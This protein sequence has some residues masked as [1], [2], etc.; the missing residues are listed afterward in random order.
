MDTFDL[1]VIGA[2]RAGVAAAL[3]GA[4]AG[5]RVCL[6]EQ[7][8]IG[9][10][11]MRKGLYPF[12]AAM[13]ALRGQGADGLGKGA[14]DIE[15]LFQSI[16]GTGESIADNWRSQLAERGVDVRL[17]RG[18]LVSPTHIRA[19]SEQ[20][21]FEV[22][23]KT[24]VLAAG[25][26]PMAM[27]TLPY[28]GESIISTDDIFRIKKVPESVLISGGGAGGCEWATLFSLLGSKVF[29]CDEASRL[30]TGQEPEVMDAIER[31]MKKRKVKLL[32]GRKIV[33]HYKN[34]GLLDISLDGGVKFQVETIVLN[35]ARESN[36]SGLGCE[37]LGLRRGE[38]KEVLVNEILE[39]S[40]AGI[41]SAGSVSGRVS[42]AGISEEEGRVAADNALGKK[43]QI[44]PDWIPFIVRTDPEIA[45][46]GC[47]AEEAHHKGFRAVE[48][49]CGAGNP[50]YAMLWRRPESFFKVVAD[51]KSGRVIGGQVVSPHASELISL[52][53]LA[54]K[55]GMKVG[56]LAALAT[57]GTREIQG[58]QEAARACGRALKARAKSP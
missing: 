12:T 52:V 4:E 39:T 27:P 47:F 36:S 34:D 46:V 20:E 15:R 16:N 40:V 29:L 42:P 5:A 14:V 25:S 45:T 37:G 57:D 53:L 31:S 10:A 2:G 18:T 3:R 43:R 32:L 21:S 26:R 24:I 6:L 1:A 11:C 54:V 17:G 56:A 55:K 58:I 49:V 35:L 33:S 38:R 8:A 51:A 30:L 44:D 7:D 50:D 13:A 23:A 48:G 19:K 9:A 22:H 41:F 28:D